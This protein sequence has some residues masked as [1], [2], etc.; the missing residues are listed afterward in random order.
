MSVRF[1]IERVFCDQ[2][3]EA[4]LLLL[5]SEDYFNERLFRTCIDNQHLVVLVL[6]FERIVALA[7]TDD[8]LALRD[9]WVALAELTKRL[10]VF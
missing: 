9:G 10:P 1:L 6:A 8:V 2:K 7:V 4:Q 3:R 5:V